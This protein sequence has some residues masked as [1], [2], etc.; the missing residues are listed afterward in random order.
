MEASF[1]LHVPFCLGLCD[2]CDFYS[3]SAVPDDPRFDE[4]VDVLLQDV[5]N[6][7]QYFGVE[8]VPSLYIGGGTP[9]LLG[10]SRMERLLR[11]LRGLLPTQP[12]EITVEANPESASED[13]I[14]ACEASGVTRLSLGV[15]SREAEAR[16]A[17]GR[18]GSLDRIA[19]A[20]ENA[21]RGFSG[22][23]SIDLISGLPFQTASS[24]SADIEFASS[25]G[26][27]HVSLYSLTVEPGT[28]LYERARKRRADLP[29]ADEADELW[30]GGRDA[31]ELSGFR[32]YEVSNF[33]LPGKE[34]LHNRRYWRMETY[35]GCGPGAV[36]TVV[37]EEKASA[38]R[39]SWPPDVSEWLR[40]EDSGR[41]AECEPIGRKDFLAECLIMGF[42]TLDG[43]D[44]GLFS[45]RFGGGSD[46][47]IGRTLSRWR[48]RGLAETDRP[49]LNRDGLLRLNGFLVECLEELDLSYPRYEESRL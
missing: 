48:D 36:G 45:R 46:R 32:Q 2:Y 34:S 11:G 21:A 26:A 22:G 41:R 9:S 17:V 25:C 3:I 38:R 6:S 37:D 18:R 29:D 7:I 1:Y 43:V 44:E 23:L 13:F 40:A 12:E 27:E 42:R 5:R 16:R 15:Q 19:S 35:I 30:I 20:V 10:P 39:Y 33:S 49:A 24:L 4:F 8:R 28:P 47:F 31:L 14:L